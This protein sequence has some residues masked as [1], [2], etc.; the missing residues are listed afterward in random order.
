MKSLKKKQVESRLDDLV[1]SVICE[2]ADDANDRAEELNS[3]AEV[4]VDHLEWTELDKELC[5]RLAALRQG[6]QLDH[7]Q[8]EKIADT[9]DRYWSALSRQFFISGCR[10]GM[11]LK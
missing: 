10:I 9:Y 7:A 11:Q 8:W 1:H 6:I 3:L 4:F 2:N 5:Q